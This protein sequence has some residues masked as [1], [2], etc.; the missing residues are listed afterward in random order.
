MFG[1]LIESGS[2]KEEL[3][4]KGSFFLGT[5]ALYATLLSGAGIA[6]IYAFNVRLDNENLEM[7]GLVTPVPPLAEQR[8]RQEARPASPSHNQPEPVRINTGPET[9][10]PQLMPKGISVK[11]NPVPQAFTD[12]VKTGRENSDLGGI[13]IG[14]P[15]GLGDGD[16]AENGHGRGVRVKEAGAPPPLLRPTPSPTPV[17]I[18]V[19]GRVLNG[20]AISLP[21]P[22]YPP[23]AKASHASGTVT[24]QVL[25][26]E[27][28]RVI[29]AQAT[30]GPSSLRGVA[31]EAAYRARFTPTY[32][33]KVPVKVSGFITYNFVL[34]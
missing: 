5:L 9:I 15:S 29:S 32:L 34:E 17:K 8:P 20:R 11:R 16:S 7:I 30:G 26:D 3:A 21:A 10:N 4:R 12:L 24:V 2:H 31:V 6:S 19:S 18:L 14:P 22:P 23:I 28:G 1:N 13:E 25:I 33:S 27:Q